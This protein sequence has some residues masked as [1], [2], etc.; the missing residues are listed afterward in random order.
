MAKLIGDRYDVESCLGRGAMGEVF[1]AAD[2]VLKR[3]VAIKRIRSS[4]VSGPDETA[5]ARLRRE[6]Q[7]AATVHHPNVVTIHDL[8]SEDDLYIVMEYVQG[9]TVDDLLRGDTTLDSVAAAKMGTQVA[10]ALEAAHR[11][12]V[13]HRDVKPANILLAEDSGTAKLA[14]FGI[15]RS[16]GDTTL[17]GTGL[18]IGAVAY[19]APEVANGERATTAS[20]IYSL[21]S[22]LFAA[23]EGHPPFVPPD[24]HATPMQVLARLLRE[25]APPA[26]RAGPLAGLI[27]RML[28]VDPAA[29]PTAGEVR[30]ALSAFT[31]GDG[32]GAHQAS[33]AGEASD[34]SS[35]E[36][37]PSSPLPKWGDLPRTL[38]FG[39]V[40][41][42][43]VER[44][45]EP[46]EG[47]MKDRQPIQP[48]AMSGNQPDSTRGQGTG[49]LAATP[50]SDQVSSLSGMLDAPQELLKTGPTHQ[51]AGRA[52]RST[53][54]ALA[55]G[56]V[57]VAM[58]LMGTGWVVTRG[59]LVSAPQDPD[60]SLALGGYRSCALT[61]KGGVKCWGD[62]ENG[63]L[64]DGTNT[65]RSQPVDVVGLGSGVTAIS[66]NGNSSCALTSSGAVKCWGWN[67]SG[68]LG[69]GTTKDRSTPVDVVGLG[70]DVTAIAVGEGHACAIVGAGVKCWG[71][72]VY[73]ALG[74]GTRTDRSTPVDVIGL[75]SGVQA[76]GAGDLFSCALT[77]GGAVKCWGHNTHHQ[78]GDGTV[79]SQSVPVNV[80]RLG[81][82]VE[83]IDVGNIHACA[84]TTAGSV[85]CWG[86]NEAGLLGDGTTT[87]QAT[88]VEVSGLASGVKQIA[89]GGFTA[90]ALRGS[91][92]PLCWGEVDMDVFNDS[93]QLTPTP[94][95]GLA[96]D[97]IEVDISDAAH[98]CARTDTGQVECWGH[99]GYGQ[100]GDGSRVFRATP[101]PVPQLD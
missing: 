81:V 34:L 85:K 8:V 67:M 73:G 19:M 28:A 40:F 65:A 54:S 46:S 66:A 21:G 42:T 72:N 43:V 13:I 44:R 9:C 12:G 87:P 77:D 88:P 52:P 7:A 60:A 91:D 100:L 38:V 98:A 74:D 24:D 26:R 63:Q 70:S 94:I 76:I 49:G 80:A 23:T 64:G 1:L 11:V 31:S 57:L 4:T 14:D 6:A 18:V 84:L 33:P 41:P 59:T 55:I 50:T 86:N 32:A 79:K 16:A 61:S 71:N 82:N 96:A 83:A 51:D 90:C 75:G 22:T 5:L 37:R 2:T 101:V 35:D 15:A 92:A 53:R 36:A 68:E 47:H 25:P 30:K 39:E 93:V 17:T 62:N 69:D 95:D 48:F 29:R 10:A 27:A 99:N 3:K 45:S 78:L 89:V 20:D 97:V 58:V 56:A